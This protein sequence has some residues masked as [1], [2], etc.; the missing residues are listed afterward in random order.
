MPFRLQFAADPED[1]VRRTFLLVKAR[2]L[3]RPGEL[4]VV[5][6]D[7]RPANED[8]IRGVQIRRVV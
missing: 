6:S 5:V 2:G 4:V 3:V 8:V 7:L 1:N